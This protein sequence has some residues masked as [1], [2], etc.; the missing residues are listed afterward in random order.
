MDCP[1]EEALIRSKLAGIPG[2]ASLEFN[3]VQRTLHVWHAADT[4]SHVLTAL[5][6]L[7]F[8]A[9]VRSAGAPAAAEAPGPARTNWWPLAVSGVAATLAEVVYW[10]HGGNHWGV[11]ALALAAIFTGG[12]T[13]YKRAGSRS[14][15]AT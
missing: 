6:S 11:V 5:K 14:G 4:L 13:T 3:L 8:D 12:L 15:I 10:L 9:E 2:V 7:G 1:T